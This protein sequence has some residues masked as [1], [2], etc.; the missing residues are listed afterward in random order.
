MPSAARQALADHQVRQ[1]RAAGI[2][3][4][5]RRSAARAG[6]QVESAENAAQAA[7]ATCAAIA[8]REAAYIR[9]WSESGAPW[10]PPAPPDDLVEARVTGDAA[11]DAARRTASTL[12]SNAAIAQGP[13]DRANRHMRDLDELTEKLIIEVVRE[14][15][16]ISVAN[17]VAARTFAAKAEA[18][19]RALHSHLVSARCFVPA[20]AI[21]AALFG[22]RAPDIA[23]DSSAWPAFMGALVSDANAAAPSLAS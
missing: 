9:D 5:A 7:S 16:E 19:I 14:E 15:A 1:R 11:L 12:R 10:P 21:D 2:A 17:L 6:A 23:Q 22:L 18:S 13:L 4:D 3:A 20:E 8:D